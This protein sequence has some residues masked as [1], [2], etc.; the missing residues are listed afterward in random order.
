MNDIADVE[1][2]TNLPL[3]FDAYEDSRPLG[4][5]ILIDPVTNAT[6]AGGMISAAVDSRSGHFD[7]APAFIWAPGNPM[8][9]DEALRALHSVNRAAVNID[10]PSIPDSALPAVARALQL[11]DVVA[12]SARV[13]LGTD[14]VDA[15][16]EIASVAWIEGEEALHNWLKEQ[17]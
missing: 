6:V 3:F 11:A 17:R 5:F 10:D 4:S 16:R 7:S 12:L 1:L 15:L 14:I 13:D 2:H 8:L 9:I